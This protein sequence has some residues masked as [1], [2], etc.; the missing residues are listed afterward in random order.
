MGFKQRTNIE[1]VVAEKNS[2]A[3]IHKELKIYMVSFLLIKAMLVVEFHHLRALRNAKLSPAMDV[4]LAGQQLSLRHCCKVLM[5]KYYRRITSRK[6]ATQLS[7]SNGSVNTIIDALGYSK[8]CDRWVPRSLTDYHKTEVCSDSL[9]HY[10]LL[11]KA[12]CGGSSLGMKHG[13]ITLKRR[14]KRE[15]NGIIKLLRRSLRLPL[16]LRKSWSLL[17]GLQ[18]GWF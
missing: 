3:N 2:V 17:F 7:V 6:P 8:V 11:M 1:F 13:S 12:F 5:N 18:N 16:Q 4:T 15:W 14:Q 9:A 10:E